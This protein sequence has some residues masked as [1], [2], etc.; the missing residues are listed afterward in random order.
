MRTMIT[1]RRPAAV[2]AIAADKF[3]KAADDV[4]PGTTHSWTGKARGREIEREREKVTVVSLA[5][6]STLFA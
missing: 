6:P 1:S 3:A 2:A 5:L 4:L